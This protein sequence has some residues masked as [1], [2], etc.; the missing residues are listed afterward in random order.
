M[1][2]LVSLVLSYNIHRQ[3][4]HSDLNYKE[5]H[6]D[7]QIDDYRFN[8]GDDITKAFD[9]LQVKHGFPKANQQQNYISN[10]R[11]YALCIEIELYEDVKVTYHDVSEVNII[12]G[13]TE[14]LFHSIF[15][16][17]YK[18]VKNRVHQTNAEGDQAPIIRWN[19]CYLTVC[20]LNLVS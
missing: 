19:R 11:K 3:G 1:F 17:L 12:A 18:F 20:I 7:F 13:V 5:N 2:I 14:V 9:N 15:V 4:K 8:H 6:E 16:N 10:F